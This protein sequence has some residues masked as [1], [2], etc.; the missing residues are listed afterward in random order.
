M[1]LICDQCGAKYSIADEKVRGKVFKIRCKKCENVIVVQ[2]DAE[3]GPTA[4]G[5]ELAASTN[6]ALPAM[7]DEAVAAAQAEAEA[8]YG[9]AE[10]GAAGY[11]A[12]AGEGAAG[13][14]ADAAYDQGY[15]ADPAAAPAQGE[16]V[17]SWYLLVGQQQVG[18]LTD[19]G[20]HEYLAQGSATGESYVWKEGFTDWVQLQTLAEFAEA[21]AAAWS[22]G[23]A[24][25]APQ[26]GLGAPGYDQAGY[27]AGAGHEASAYDAAGGY[28]A[29]GTEEGA[30]GYGAQ[31]SADPAGGA[32]G[33]GVVAAAG[34]GY[35]AGVGGYPQA[36]PGAGLDLEL[37]SSQEPLGGAGY[38]AAGG[39]FMVS[40]QAPEGGGLAFPTSASPDYATA[41]S[42]LSAPPDDDGRMIG[43]R[44][45][46]SVLF[47]LAS[48]RNLADGPGPA[49]AA[50][51]PGAPAPGPAGGSTASGL[52]DIRALA[53]GEGGGA[54]LAASDGE[55]PAPAPVAAPLMVPMMARR[56]TPI[57]L[58]VGLVL[59]GLLV[60]GLSI[61]LVV[62]WMN[63]DESG[64]GKAGPMV[65]SAGGAKGGGA[66]AAK[67]GGGSG[68]PSA[69]DPKG[70][71]ASG[72]A[73]GGGGEAGD[74]PAGDGGDKPK[75]GGSDS[76]GKAAGDDPPKPVARTGRGGRRPAAAASRPS[77]APRP[78]AA[79]G[80]PTAVAAA[81]SAPKPSPAAAPRAPKPPKPRPSRGGSAARSEVDDLLSAIEQGGRKPA[82]RPAAPAPAAAR[83]PPKPAPPAPAKRSLGRDDVSRVVRANKGR[84]QSCYLKQAEP[85]LSGT[86]TVS[87][88]I[89]GSGKVGS[90][91]IRTAKFEG[92]SVGRC[93]LS[94][95]RSF[96]FPT[97]TDPPV[98]INYPFILR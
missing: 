69:E 88:A 19:A 32:Y 96:K 8:P 10:P 46:N 25:G 44:N 43:A 5:A 12:G 62:I 11:G 27:A 86:I 35:E 13:Y 17:A 66:V 23:A 73:K 70:A 7:T 94:A 80:R 89:M 87:F 93:V 63:K 77:P 9:G 14:G 84:I 76:P 37:Q 28:A 16:E 71:G 60:L 18:P 51:T 72:D 47:S 31:A 33:D 50:E 59:A 75:E 64:G 82:A 92:T 30:V 21:A 53:S 81:P 29:P 48:L 2:G 40:S 36:G 85:K 15:G 97:H 78:T 54:D 58:I 57:G 41:G 52:I 20:V 24:A 6:T 98:K 4:K 22:G 34:G 56:R 55:L 74:D 42:P 45:E 83:K 90:A 65:A 67:G 49:P 26:E 68:K 39:G 79:A 61:T 95:V 3:G 91:A 38:G 1:K